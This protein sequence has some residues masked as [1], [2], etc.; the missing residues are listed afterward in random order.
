LVGLLGG[1]GGAI[2]G[3]I[4]GAITGGV[5]AGAID[6]GFLNDDLREYGKDMAP[7]SSALVALIEHVWVERL[8]DEL[9]ALGA[10]CVAYAL[11]KAAQ[12][13]IDKLA[14]ED[15]AGEG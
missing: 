3:A 8:R 2:L 13:K 10:K 11:S 12:E 7:G 15:E 6:M 9:A 1:P 4:A 5:A 14:T